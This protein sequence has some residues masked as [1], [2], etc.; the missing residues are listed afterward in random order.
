MRIITSAL[1]GKSGKIAERIL[2]RDFHYVFY[3]HW[4]GVNPARGVGWG[5]FKQVV[6]RVNKHYANRLVWMR[7]RALTELFHRR[8]TNQRMCGI[9]T[10]LARMSY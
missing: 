4:Q 8:A 10:R 2:A 5:A 3:A 6:E 9:K 1:K 7:P